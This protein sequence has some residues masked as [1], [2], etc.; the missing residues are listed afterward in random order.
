LLCFFKGSI[1]C[2]NTRAAV[3][4]KEGEGKR[5]SGKEWE[6]KVADCEGEKEKETRQRKSEEGNRESTKR[7]K[8]RTQS[9]GKTGQKS[10]GNTEK[11]T[12]REQRGLQREKL[13]TNPKGKKAGKERESE[14]NTERQVAD[15]PKNERESKG[16]RES[17]GAD[18]SK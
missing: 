2:A 4:R 5:A 13:R 8:L 14:G 15:S 10:R 17:K 1:I 3:A 11:G 6:K 7:E 18:S 12:V 16:N 9:G